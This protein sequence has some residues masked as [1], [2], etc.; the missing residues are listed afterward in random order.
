MHPAPSTGHLYCCEYV[1]VGMLYFTTDAP[2]MHCQWN[3]GKSELW[4]LQDHVLLA[5]CLVA[6]TGGAAAYWPLLTAVSA[7]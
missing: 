4:W 5:N 6:R 2:D 1:R 3:H 7:R